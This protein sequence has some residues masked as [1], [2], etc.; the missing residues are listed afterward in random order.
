MRIKPVGTGVQGPDFPQGLQ[1][2]QFCGAVAGGIKPAGLCPL[3]LQLQ[4][5]WDLLT[6]GHWFP[7]HFR[8]K[9]SGHV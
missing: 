4:E 1:G 2:A 8:V 9:V 3:L 7:W 5:L 6:Q